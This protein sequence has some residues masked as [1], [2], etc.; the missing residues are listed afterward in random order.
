MVTAPFFVASFSSKKQLQVIHEI[1]HQ[2]V[3]VM[4]KT[5]HQKVQ[6]MI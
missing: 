3:Q 2:K 4:N 6:I 5:T 1:T